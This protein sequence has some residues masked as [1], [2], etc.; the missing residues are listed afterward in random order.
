MNIK[1]SY[2]YRDESNYKQYHS[3]VFDN[4]ENQLI[5]EIKQTITHCLID[6]TWFVADEWNLPNQFFKEYPWDNEID[7]NW[8]DLVSV[9]ETEL[10]STEAITIN[11]FLEKIRSLKKS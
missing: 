10:D 11:M 5:N 8:H 4:P 2:L 7:H 9:E 3:I 1:F 6:S